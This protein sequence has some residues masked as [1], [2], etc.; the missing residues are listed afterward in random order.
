M[1]FCDFCGSKEPT[2]VY[3]FGKDIAVQAFVESG[4]Q[5]GPTQ[6]Y[7]REWA[8]CK[9]CGEFVDRGEIMG[10]MNHVFEIYAA[11]YSYLKV[12]IH[13]RSMMEDHFNTLYGELAKHQVVRIK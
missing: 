8:A 4:P 9:T 13:S 5:V 7:T 6:V 1:G 2:R 10:L 3:D 11:R 12:F